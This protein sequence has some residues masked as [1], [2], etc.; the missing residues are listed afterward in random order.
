MTALA[1]DRP[2]PSRDAMRFSDPVKQ[3]A[4][5]YKGALV[6]LDASGDAMPGNTIANGA[7]VV[8]GVAATAADNTDGGDGAIRVEVM[9]GCFRFANSSSTDAITRA[10]IGDTAYVVD[11]QTVAKTDGSSARIAAGI[12]RDVDAAGVWVEI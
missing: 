9:R 4:V 11:D 5:I 3:A 1:K 12:I 6:V 8:R 7:A 10:E 2:I